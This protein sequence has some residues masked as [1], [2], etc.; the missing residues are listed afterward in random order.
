MIEANGWPFSAANPC[1]AKEATWAGGNYQLYTFMA[2]PLTTTATGYAW[3]TN[4]PVSDYQTGPKTSGSLA[5]QSYNY[6]YNAA[7]YAFAQANAQGVSSP[8]WWIDIEGAGSYWSADPAYNTSAIQGAADYFS[9]VGIIAGLYSGHATMYA[10]ITT[11]TTSGP[12]STILGPGGGPIPI[13][14]YSSSGIA[15]CTATTD[16]SGAL[17]PFAGGIPWYIQTAFMSNYDA[18]VAC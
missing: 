10:Q 18:D 6:G 1:M 15:A 13:W 7:A 3:P 4:V 11:G 9:Q 2:L 8:I 16:P 14:F 12:G 5:D 17:N